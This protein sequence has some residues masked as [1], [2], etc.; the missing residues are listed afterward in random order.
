MW[1]F[2]HKKT[3]VTYGFA[4]LYCNG[5]LSILSLPSLTPNVTAFFEF[6]RFFINY[7]Y[8]CLCVQN[9][10]VLFWSRGLFQEENF[11]IVWYLAPLV[12]DRLWLK[13]WFLFTWIIV[14]VKKARS[15]VKSRVFI[16]ATRGSVPDLQFFKMATNEKAFSIQFYGQGAWGHQ[17]IAA[18]DNHSGSCIGDYQRTEEWLQCPRCKV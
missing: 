9:K 4:H 14:K 12:Q 18:V 13:M 16:L 2:L 8:A 7:I 6:Y 3:R 5:H 10:W 15:N 17:K 11:A 1:A